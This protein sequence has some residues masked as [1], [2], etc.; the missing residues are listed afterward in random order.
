M[1]FW[2]KWIR[3]SIPGWAKKSEYISR[4]DR[5]S[6]MKVGRTIFVRSMPMRTY[7]WKSLFARVNQPG[8]LFGGHIIAI[9]PAW[10]FTQKWYVHMSN[11]K[12]ITASY[13]TISNYNYCNR[14]RT[15]VVGPIHHFCVVKVPFDRMIILYLMHSQAM[16]QHN[17]AK[18]FPSICLTS[19]FS[20]PPS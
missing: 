15:S 4:R 17:S 18:P 14:Y 19:H 11:D 8:S 1:G 13:N 2:K 12:Y 7:K 9:K 5:R 6:R 20:P 16:K 10:V 3:K